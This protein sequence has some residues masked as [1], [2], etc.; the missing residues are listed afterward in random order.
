MAGTLPHDVHPY[1]QEGMLVQVTR[2][3]L[4]WVRGILVHKD[5]PYRL[6][7]AVHLLKQAAAVEIDAAD[8]E[9]I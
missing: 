9:P 6:V 3:L 8:A 7:I 1:L 2:G 4:E 5:K